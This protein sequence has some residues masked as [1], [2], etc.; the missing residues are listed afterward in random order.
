MTH[1]LYK[2]CVIRPC[3]HTPNSSDQRD[4]QRHLSSALAVL[5][6][7]AAAHSSVALAAAWAVVLEP[8]VVR[9]STQLGPVAEHR[10]DLR[11]PLHRCVGRGHIG[12]L[13]AV[14]GRNC[15]F[16]RI[17]AAAEVV[18]RFVV[19]KM[20]WDLVSAHFHPRLCRMP[21]KEWVTERRR[22]RGED[23]KRSKLPMGRRWMKMQYSYLTARTESRR[24][25]WAL[26]HLRKRQT[27]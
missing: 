19:G 24:P 5:A 25:T 17:A 12:A 4:R 14:A 27:R 6:A 18:G 11:T 8:V 15:S 16:R 1:L 7:A 21:A 20:P 26:R 2:P 9:A 13:A 23:Q 22:G 3:P 10:I